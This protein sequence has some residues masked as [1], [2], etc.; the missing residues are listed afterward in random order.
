MFHNGQIIRFFNDGD[1]KEYD[2]V[3]WRVLNE[4]ETNISLVVRYVDIVN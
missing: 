3:V 2:G 1:G 4:D